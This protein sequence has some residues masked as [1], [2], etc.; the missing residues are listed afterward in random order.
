MAALHTI[1]GTKRTTCLRGPQTVKPHNDCPPQRAH[2]SGS[3]APEQTAYR[4]PGRAA[5]GHTK[6]DYAMGPPRIRYL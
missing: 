4:T 1:D 6:S 5:L 2:L 3:A